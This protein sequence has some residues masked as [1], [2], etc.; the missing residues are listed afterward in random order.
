MFGNLFQFL[1]PSFMQHTPSFKI[2]KVKLHCTLQTR[3]ATGIPQKY[4]T[5]GA[6]RGTTL[7]PFLEL[8]KRRLQRRKRHSSS[9]NQIQ[10][11]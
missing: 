4:N 6:K 7:A 3:K 1:P 10:C 9:L 11:T 8:T 2:S 5:L